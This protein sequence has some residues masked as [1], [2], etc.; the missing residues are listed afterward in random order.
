MIYQDIDSYAVF[1]ELFFF[2]DQSS[3]LFSC[4]I[5]EGRYL[6]LGSIEVFNAV[7]E[8][9][10]WTVLKFVEQFDFD[11]SELYTDAMDWNLCT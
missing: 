11:I 8:T 3:K 6:T 7:G 1:Q 4:Q 9:K 10:S 5:K 2:I